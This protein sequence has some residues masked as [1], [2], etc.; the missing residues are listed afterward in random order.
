MTCKVC[1]R[2][3]STT[4]VIA[5]FA[6]QTVA[7]RSPGKTLTKSG[8]SMI[9]R[10]LPAALQGS[11]K[12]IPSKSMAH[13]LLIC[14][15]LA[16]EETAV[17]CQGTSRDIEATAACLQAMGT[18]IAGHYQV[19]P[20]AKKIFCR[21]P[22]GESGS[23]LRFLLPVAAALGLEAEFYME[24]R[25]PQRPISPLDR[26]LMNHGVTLTKPQPDVLRTSGQLRPGDYVLPGNVSSQYIS[27]LLFALP[28][29]PGV[30]TLTVTGMVE[31]A[32]LLK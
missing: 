8:D 32:A 20:G 24:G 10:I 5:R 19:V 22:C 26:Q 7:I 31:S 1:F 3:L 25:L 2:N 4:T 17:A 12:A 15:A 23:T 16:Q 21:L 14:A 9:Q 30:S 18:L 11:I 13:R 29:L 27:G 6:Q 28:L